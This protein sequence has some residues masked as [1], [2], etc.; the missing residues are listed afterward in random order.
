[1]KEKRVLIIIPS[2]GIGGTM[3]SLKALLSSIDCPY[4]KVDIFPLYR[5]GSNSNSIIPN[6]HIL[7]ESIWLS[8]SIKKSRG[9][10]RYIQIV[11]QIIK[12]VLSLLSI[13]I[14]PFYARMGARE[15]NFRQYDCVISYSEDLTKFVSF[16]P[17]NRK[18]AWTHSVY[19]RY[20]GLIGGI[21]ELKYYKCYNYIICVSEYAKADF[22]SVYSSLKEKVRVIYNCCDEN[23]LRV[24]SQEFIPIEYITKQKY[25]QLTF[26][27]VGRLDP[28][29]QFSC[30]PQIARDVK[31]KV[32][33]CFKWFIIGGA[34]GNGEEAITI[35]LRIKELGVE[36]VVFLIGEKTNPYPYIANSDVFVHTS[37]SETFG[38]VV[39][40]ALVL[41]VPVVLNNYGSASETVIDGENGIITSLDK[42]ASTI[43]KIITDGPYLQRLKQQAT[44]VEHRRAL[45]H[46]ETP[47]KLL[48]LL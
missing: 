21:D 17:I 44:D 33:P 2:F 46:T 4:L 3:S 14:N 16:L 26:V 27:S 9:L 18:I 5:A 1:M 43:I 6:A 45:L 15:L 42:I 11:L 30:I 28:V 20:K 37:S 25:K 38:I 41:G 35:S 8:A 12:K 32:G 22:I 48:D 7:K 40:E 29:K 23:R 34:C 31:E 10:K 24:L 36:D 39:Q 47:N 13:D 19:S